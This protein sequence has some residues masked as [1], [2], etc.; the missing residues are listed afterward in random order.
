MSSM[1]RHECNSELHRVRVPPMGAGMVD[2]LT[3]WTG[4]VCALIGYDYLT[5]SCLYM[6]DTLATSN[7]IFNN[8]LQGFN[9]LI[10][11]RG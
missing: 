3:G 6:L 10:P 2:V 5:R 4:T 11:K 1:D 7:V 8:N 9:S